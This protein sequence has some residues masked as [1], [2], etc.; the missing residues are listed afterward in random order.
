MTTA[1]TIKLTLSKEAAFAAAFTALAVYFP[2]ILHHFGGPAAG[3]KFLPMPFFVILAGLVL[4]WR[5]GLVAGLASSVSSFLISGM[6]A[7]NVLPFVT[8]QLC[9]YGAVAG[10]LKARY[11]VWISI[12]GALLS[13]LLAGGISV[14]LFSKMSAAAFT[15]GA[16]RD[17]WLG[18]VIQLLLLPLILFFFQKFLSDEKTIQS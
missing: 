8:V 18:I 11:N 5:A 7:A 4:G 16:A 1:Q 13:G 3:R 15:F 12:F 17:G 9:F 10:I 14:F 2:M 6:P